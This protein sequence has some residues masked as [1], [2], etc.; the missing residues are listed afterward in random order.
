[1]FVSLLHVKKPS[2]LLLVYDKEK[3]K[4][5]LATCSMRGSAEDFVDDLFIQLSLGMVHIMPLLLELDFGI[6]KTLLPELWIQ[7]EE[8][9]RGSQY[10]L[11][12]F[13]LTWFLYF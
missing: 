8:E 4:F 11:C 5:L 2:S 7:L 6:L 3:C 12:K 9:N 1:M 13:A 10:L